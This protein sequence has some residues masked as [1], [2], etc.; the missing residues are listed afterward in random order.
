MIVDG[1]Y[2]MVIVVSRNERN[3]NENW[4]KREEEKAGEANH[5]CFESP[6]PNISQE[7]T[8]RIEHSSKC[9]RNLCNTERWY[10]NIA[11]D[12]STWA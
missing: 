5:D 6:T 1:K 2:V 11:V 4:Y 3:K 8:E 9:K 7:S 12:K 10:D